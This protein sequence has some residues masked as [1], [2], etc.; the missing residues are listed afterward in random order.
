MA[1]IEVTAQSFDPGDGSPRGNPRTEIIDTDTNFLFEDCKSLT[2][3]TE[4]YMAFWNRL[5]TKQS[6]MVLVQSI[7]WLNG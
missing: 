3:V 4:K 5:P 7:R 1:R 2:G 6:E